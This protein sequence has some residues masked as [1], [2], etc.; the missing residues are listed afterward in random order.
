MWY[1]ENPSEAPKA[2]QATPTA[3]TAVSLV[4]LAGRTRLLLADSFEPADSV[5]QTRGKWRVSFKRRRT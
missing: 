2:S 5:I 4:F 3:G 1:S